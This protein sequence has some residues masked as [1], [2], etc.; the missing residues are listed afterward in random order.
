MMH[1]LRDRVGLVD[2]QFE[3]LGRD[4]VDQGHRLV[5]IGDEDDCAIVPPARAC[6]L[7]ARQALEV[8]R[9]LPFD[10][11]GEIG[12]VGEEDGLGG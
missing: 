3:M 5:P 9:D 7:G 2:R 6:D 10:R 12:V 8:A 11:A 1:P 4:A